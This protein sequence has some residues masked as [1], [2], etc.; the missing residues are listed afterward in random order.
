M[1]GWRFFID[2]SGYRDIALEVRWQQGDG[3]FG[4]WRG[5]RATAPPGPWRWLWAPGMAG[6]L[7]VP[8]ALRTLERRNAAGRDSDA[9]SSLAYAAALSFVRKQA[10]DDG[11]MALQFAV[12]RPTGGTRDVRFLSQVHPC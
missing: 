3:S 12:V 11:A 7:S 9:D 1:P 8:A 2:P 5:A 4:P 6:T 10:A